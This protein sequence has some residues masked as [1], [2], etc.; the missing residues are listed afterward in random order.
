MFRRLKDKRLHGDFLFRFIRGLQ[1]CNID[2][3]ENRDFRKKRLELLKVLS[4][5]EDG[6]EVHR[7]LCA[8]FILQFRNP[9][10]EGSQ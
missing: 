3:L 4:Q 10:T 8:H 6:D 7:L 5:G 2:C 9:Y 1:T